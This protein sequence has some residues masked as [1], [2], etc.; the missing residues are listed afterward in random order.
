[1]GEQ[2]HDKPEDHPDH[3]HGGPPGQTG[4]NPGHGGGGPPG[5]EDKP[6]TPGHGAEEHPEHPIVIQP[7]EPEEETH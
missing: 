3:P 6:D 2:S 1:M 7:D 5:Q 4:E